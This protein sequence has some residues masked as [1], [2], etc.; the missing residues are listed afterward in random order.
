MHQLSAGPFVHRT[1]A[2]MLPRHT[3][4]RYLPAFRSATPGTSSVPDTSSGL[5]MSP[6]AFDQLMAHLN[7]RVTFDPVP[8][9]IRSQET[10]EVIGV[11]QATP[12]L[13]GGT[14][15]AGSTVSTTAP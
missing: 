15:A 6:Q 9:M 8:I 5:P 4:D 12:R 2:A 1:Q 11:G 7:L 13:L 14:E 3:R 10:G